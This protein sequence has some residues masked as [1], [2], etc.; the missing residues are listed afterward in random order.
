MSDAMQQLHSISTEHCYFSESGIISIASKFAYLTSTFVHKPALRPVDAVRELVNGANFSYSYQ[1]VREFLDYSAISLCDNQQIIRQGDLLVIEVRNAT[2]ESSYE[3]AV[4]LQSDR[5]QS[6]PTIR[7]AAFIRARI[8]AVP[9]C[10]FESFDFDNALIDKR[11]AEYDLNRDMS[12]AIVFIFDP[13][14]HPLEYMKAR[15]CAAALL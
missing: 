4:V 1:S 15:D 11:A 9:K 7:R 13:V 10:N 8:T 14:F 3:L 6:R 12:R 2:G 5:F